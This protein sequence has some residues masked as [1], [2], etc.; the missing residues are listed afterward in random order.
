M[1]FIYLDESGD[2]GFDFCKTK[3]SKYFVITFLF[4]KDSKPIEKI[5]KKVY[6]SFSPRELKTH[7]G[8]L[9]CFKEKPATRIKLL[10]MLN[11]KDIS[12]VSVFLNKKNVFD[13]LKNKKHILY[14]YVTNILLD[15]VY[16]NNLIPKDKPICLI[17][18]KRE[19]NKFLNEN[20]TQYLK[21]QVKNNHEINLS[22]EIKTPYENKCLQVVDFVCWAIFRK[23]EHGDC[24]YY[25]IIE[26]KIIGEAPLF[27]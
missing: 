2:L 21:S 27:L 11:N 23:I 22:I 9:H 7:S 12:I 13:K 8:V 18:S 17:A 3:T 14:N 5:I 15:R 16:S 24:Q 19:T 10:S 20:F 6:Q 26:K 4:S 25:N 1:G